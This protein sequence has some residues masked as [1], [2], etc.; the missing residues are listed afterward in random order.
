M[1]KSCCK[2][3]CLFHDTG[4]LK[5]YRGHEEASVEICQ[6]IL[7]HYGYSAQNIE[8]ISSMIVTTKLPQCASHTWI[9]SCVIADLDYLGR[10]TTS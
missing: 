4:M 7:P 9:R 8:V 1:R 3:A 2:T 10:P 6:E 5:T